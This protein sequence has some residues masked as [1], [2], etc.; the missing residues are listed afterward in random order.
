LF[1]ASRLKQ[2]WGGD[3]LLSLRQQAGADPACREL[4]ILTLYL[5]LS[6]L[7]AASLALAKYKSVLVSINRD[8]VARTVFTLDN[9]LCQRVFDPVLH[10]PAQRSCA[11]DRVVAKTG[12]TIQHCV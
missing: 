12:D 11:V 7:E 9:T 6:R 4:A 3:Y 1:A 10:C 5:Y 2:I 8:A